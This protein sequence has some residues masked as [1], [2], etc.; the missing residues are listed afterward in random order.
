MMARRRGSG[1][2][3]RG[4]GM[5]KTRVLVGLSLVAAVVAAPG[6]AAAQLWPNGSGPSLDMLRTSIEQYQRLEPPPVDANRVA[7]LPIA[8][9]G[10]S[11][12]D[13]G[14][15]VLALPAE[16]TARPRTATTARRPVRRTAVRRDGTRSARVSAPRVSDGDRLERDLAARE[17]RLEE[18]QRQIEADRARLEQRR[19][20][21][22]SAFNPIPPAAAATLPPT[23]AP[24]EPPRLPPPT[25]TLR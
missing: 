25:A 22:L 17:R 13:V 14:I 11:R 24:A 5:V 15:P 16:P 20:G 3:D 6:P 18:L 4:W 21:G 2:T 12:V 8:P 9:S 1:L 10:A 7:A 19:G 23:L